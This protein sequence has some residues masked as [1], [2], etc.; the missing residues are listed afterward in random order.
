MSETLRDL[1]VRGLEAMGYKR[2]HNARSSKYLVFSK[3]DKVKKVY[4]GKAGAVRAGKT[5]ASSYSLS[6]S[7]KARLRRLAR[8][9]DDASLAKL[10]KS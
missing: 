10:M 6:D 7:S 8:E 5:I 4:V 2:D 3:G 9:A 1:H